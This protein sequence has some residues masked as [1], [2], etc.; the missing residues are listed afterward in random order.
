ME[1]Y[2]TDIYTHITKTIRQI[3]NTDILSGH[4]VTEP[5]YLEHARGY[6]LEFYEK[7]NN[8][9]KRRMSIWRKEFDKDFNLIWEDIWPE[10]LDFIQATVARGK[11]RKLIKDINAMSAKAIITE[12]M[13]KAGLKF[14]LTAQAYRARIEVKLSEK[15]KALF[16]LKYKLINEEIGH[17]VETATSLRTLIASMGKDGSIYEIR[18]WEKWE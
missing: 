2:N 3:I 18:R 10:V 16:Y 13:E 11:K 5:Q 14:I 7:K 8:S 1:T 17:V 9:A 6:A 15:C 12:A 4:N